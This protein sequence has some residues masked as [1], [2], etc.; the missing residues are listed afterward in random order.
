MIINKLTDDGAVKINNQLISLTLFSINLSESDKLLI[1]DYLEIARSEL[2]ININSEFKNRELVNLMI[3]ANYLTK[4][5]SEIVMSSQ[6]YKMM[7]N[8]IIELMKNNR[9]VKVA[10]V[11]DYLSISR[12]NTLLIL[13]HLDEQKIT[14]RNGDFRSLNIK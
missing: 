11:R 7:V 9:D 6:D 13:E 14:K 4:I 3:Q 12:K 10:E 2:F 8:K 5:D 1:N